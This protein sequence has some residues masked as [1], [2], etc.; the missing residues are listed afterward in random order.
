MIRGWILTLYLDEYVFRTP[1]VPTSLLGKCMI[2][3][4]PEARSQPAPGPGDLACVE[5]IE[6]RP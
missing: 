1:E 6:T 4:E 3:P 5:C 2:F